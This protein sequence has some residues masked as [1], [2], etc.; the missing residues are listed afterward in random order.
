MQHRNHTSRNGSLPH[1]WRISQSPSVVRIVRLECRRDFRSSTQSAWHLICSKVY[2]LERRKKEKHGE[3]NFLKGSKTLT[4]TLYNIQC[5]WK[6]RET[7]KLWQWRLEIY[8]S[9]AWR[10]GK[11][12]SQNLE[13]HPPP[14]SLNCYSSIV[15]VYLDSS[16]RDYIYFQLQVSLKHSE[17]G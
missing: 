16:L 15:L 11:R 12:G 9:E 10:K 13:F 3:D 4:W 14:L 2:F 7:S 5:V 8:V 17:S 1:G 6:R